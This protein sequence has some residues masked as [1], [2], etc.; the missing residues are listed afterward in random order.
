MYLLV[1]VTGGIFAF[2]WLVLLLREANLAE[3]KRGGWVIL[4]TILLGG[5]ALH[6]VLFALL[7][8]HPLPA[9]P[10]LVAADG[11]LALALTGLW[12]SFVVI[13]TNK[14]RYASGLAAS[15]TEAI[16]ML[17]LSILVFVSLPILQWRLNRIAVARRQPGSS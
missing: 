14:T 7:L 9:P 6:L 8:S 3:G 1:L 16:V 4:S 10:I 11:A 15:V 12:M 13:V 17:V 2:A 5:L